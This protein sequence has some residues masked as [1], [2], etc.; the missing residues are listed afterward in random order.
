MNTITNK[1]HSTSCDYGD[2]ADVILTSHRFDLAE[3]NAKSGVWPTRELGTFLSIGTNRL[4]AT[5]YQLLMGY[6][7]FRDLKWPSEVIQG[8]GHCGFWILATK[9]ILVF[10]SNYRSIYHR[11]GAIGDYICTWPRSRTWPRKITQG[12]RSRCTSTDLC[13]GNIFVTRHP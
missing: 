2:A 13:M 8:Q 11:L 10:L 5:V 12:Q 1:T 4:Q 3:S 9:F 7:H 6:F